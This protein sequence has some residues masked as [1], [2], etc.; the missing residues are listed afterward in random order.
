MS[1]T[2]VIAALVIGYLIGSIPIGRLFVRRRPQVDLGEREGGDPG[3]MALSAQLGTKSALPALLGEAV[4]G[5]L[6]GLIGLAIA[7][8][9][10][11]Y[12]CIA[13]AMAGTSLPAFARLRGGSMLMVLI[14]AA[15]T[16]QVIS[17]IIALE[18]LIIVA[19]L[20]SRRWGERIGIASF[21]L[22][23]VLI[24]RNA[25]A[26]ATVGLLVLLYLGHLRVRYAR[27]PS[28]ADQLARRA[29]R[30]AKRAEREASKAGKQ[31]AKA[32]KLRSDADEHA[33][34]AQDLAA[35]AERDAGEAERR[36]AEAKRDQPTP[37][38]RRAT[39]AGERAAEA[40]RQA[41]GVNGGRQNAGEEGPADEEARAGRR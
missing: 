10:G 16:L 17:W 12:I 19:M 11:Q 15:L 5:F 37:T 32:Q 8:K 13:A 41:S 3:A 7:H 28:E 9:G 14:G 39:E 35:T 6:A 36:A 21:P 27:A 23:Q 33:E 30:R 20:V 29:A 2:G 38:E 34:V 40:G 22:W 18:L 24:D 1:T 26:L 4:K 25:Y 31:R